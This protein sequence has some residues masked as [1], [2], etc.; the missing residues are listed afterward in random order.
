MG[1]LHCVEILYYSVMRYEN[2]PGA[3]VIFIIFHRFTA[4]CTLKS[5][6][7]LLK[8]TTFA[9][10]MYINL[11]QHALFCYSEISQN[12][13]LFLRTLLL[14]FLPRVRV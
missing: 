4:F 2:Y 8:L 9:T 5:A 3:S 7:V 6:G 13:D 10:W 12:V 11:R 14:V 1:N